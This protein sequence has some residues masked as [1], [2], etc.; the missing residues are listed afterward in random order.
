M[1]QPPVGAHLIWE[2]ANYIVMA[3]GGPNVRCDYH[4]NQGEEFF[5]QVIGTMTLKIVDN[6]EF[7]DIPIGPG[8]IFL[9]PPNVPHSP[10][11]PADTVGL[12]LESKRVPGEL[13]VVRFYCAN[14][15]CRHVLLEQSFFCTDLP[16]QLKPVIN[17]FFSDVARRTCPLCGHVTEKPTH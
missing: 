8:E 4:I 12:V 13:D 5:Y 17:E 11:R 3:V 10:Q 7:R 9:L 15:A 2:D 1:L 16:A 14:E 6:G